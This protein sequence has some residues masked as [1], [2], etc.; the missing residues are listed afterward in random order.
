MPSRTGFHDGE[1]AMHQILKVQHG[2]NPT[3]PGLPVPYAMRVMQSPLVA[4]GTLDKDGQPWT[5]IW[6][7]Q[8]GFAQPAAK[9]V[10]VLNS[11]V[12]RTFDPVFGA[13][14]DGY[15]DGGMVDGGKLMSG[16][17]IDLETRDRVKLA[18][19]M[20]GGVQD[21]EENSAQVVMEVSES[22]GNCPKY[23]NKKDITPHGVEG[24]KL[25]ASGLPLTEA[26]VDLVGRADLFFLSSTSEEAMDT[27]HRGG[28]PGFMRVLRNEDGVVEL[29]YPE[30]M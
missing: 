2:G 7:G 16:L 11:V 25:E 23:L 21:D 19:K 10:L 17:S 15:T 22:I 6:G 8:R 30:C 26:A 20:L 27:N 18:G 5:T 24:A 28:P 1:V 12:D 3:A 14:W 29:V 4:V 9:G 13:F